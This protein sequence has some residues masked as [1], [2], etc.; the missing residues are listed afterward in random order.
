MSC[1]HL[2]SGGWILDREGS[3]FSQ[4]VTTTGW[5]G[6]PISLSPKD[7][8]HSQTARCRGGGVQIGSV[9]DVLMLLW[10][11]MFLPIAGMIMRARLGTD[12]MG[13]V[14]NGGLGDAFRR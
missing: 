4:V 14:I 13:R 5:G 3:G 1:N 6:G 10:R 8:A 11:L 12:K 9:N 2:G 7:T